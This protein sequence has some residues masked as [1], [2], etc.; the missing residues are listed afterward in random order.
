[1]ITLDDVVD[2]TR[3]CFAGRDV[4]FAASELPENLV[5]PGE[6]MDFGVVLKNEQRFP[7]SWNIFRNDLPW[8]FSLLER[9]LIGTVIVA[10][11]DVELAYIFHDANGLYYY[12][13]GL[14]LSSSSSSDNKFAALTGKLSRF[15]SSVH[16]GFTFFPARSAGPEKQ[17]DDSFVA[18]LIDEEETSF[19]DDWMTIFSNGGGDYLAIDLNG[20]DQDKG[21]IWWHEEPMDPETDVNIFEIMDT[22]IS[23]FLEDTQLRHEIIVYQSDFRV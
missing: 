16:N 1:M 14:P 21:I 15:Y 23:I 17:E 19:A 13:G 3:A 11:E 12:V 18:E 7:L 9:C 4:Y 20:Q 5:L 22:W 10:G 2:Q 6:W 8:V